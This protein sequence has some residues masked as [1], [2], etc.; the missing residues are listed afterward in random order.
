MLKLRPGLEPEEMGFVVLTADKNRHGPDI[1]AGAR[2]EYWLD[3]ATGK[4]RS[5]EGDAS[6]DRGRIRHTA[7]TP[8]VP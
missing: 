7:M 6:L 3:K 8:G 4:L 2:A 5:Y 1:N